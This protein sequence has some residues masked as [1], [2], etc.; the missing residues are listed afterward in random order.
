[1]RVLV[2]LAG[3]V[4]A[5][6]YGI[7]LWIGYTQLMPVA[8]GMAP[9]DLRVFGY[10]LAEATTYLQALGDEGRALIE[11]PVRTWDT[12]FPV[13][14]TL[15]LALVSL[16][17][18]GRLG[19]IGA[20]VALGYGAADL[21][22][23]AGILQLVRGPIPPDQ[24]LVSSTSLLTQAKFALVALALLLAVVARLRRRGRA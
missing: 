12:V 15:F 8:D 20:V 22:E 14:F 19:W 24:L 21:I 10:D 1:M 18:G 13:A 16:R 23:N 6:S 3:L 4:A 11:G 9:F 7:L 2:G 5:V 17:G